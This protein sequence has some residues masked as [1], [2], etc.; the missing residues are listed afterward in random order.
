MKNKVYYLLGA[1]GLILL[2]FHNSSITG[3]AIFDSS[4]FKISILDIFGFLMLLTCIIGMSGNRTKTITLEQL[5][6]EWKDI[7][8]EEKLPSLDSKSAPKVMGKVPYEKK[9]FV[10]DLADYQIRE[11]LDSHNIPEDLTAASDDQLVKA[12]ETAA[13][14]HVQVEPERA[15]GRHNLNSLFGKASQNS[16]ISEL[17][18]AVEKRIPRELLRDSKFGSFNPSDQQLTNMVWEEFGSFQKFNEKITTLYNAHKIFFDS[19]AESQQKIF[20]NAVDSILNY[21]GKKFTEQEAEKFAYEE[22]PY[23]DLHSWI[24]IAR[25]SEKFAEIPFKRKKSSVVFE[26]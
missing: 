20:K 25:D 21:Q 15:Y 8:G 12:Y 10:Y 24:K 19:F 7:S 11:Q 26:D 9:Q 13:T 3:F 18:D 22:I 17:M 14:L 23:N 6:H 2:L 4:S 1:L 16:L 5:A